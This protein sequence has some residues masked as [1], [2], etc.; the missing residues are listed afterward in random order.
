[1]IKIISIDF[2]RN[3]R[4][5]LIRGGIL[6]VVIVIQVIVLIYYLISFK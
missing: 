1:M 4:R 2:I 5:I 3:I 6:L